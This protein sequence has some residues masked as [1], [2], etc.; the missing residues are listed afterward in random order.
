[1][2]KWSSLAKTA[3]P[4]RIVEAASIASSAGVETAAA[5][6]PIYAVFVLLI[7]A[8]IVSMVVL[9]ANRNSKE[10]TDT[11]ASSKK[12]VFEEVPIVIQPKVLQQEEDPVATKLASLAQHHADVQDAIVKPK[13]S[14]VD[15]FFS[16]PEES[17]DDAVLADGLSYNEYLSAFS[18]GREMPVS[19][20]GIKTGRFEA[21][22]GLQGRELE[23]YLEANDLAVP[24]A[25]VD[26]W[27]AGPMAGPTV[28][29]ASH[30]D[31][32]EDYMLL[33]RESMQAVPMRSAGDAA[34]VLREILAARTE[35]AKLGLSMPQMPEDQL[36]NVRYWASTNGHAA[37]L[38][39]SVLSRL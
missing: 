22:G 38:A 9:G 29:A 28:G 25:L 17:L 7:I 4:A 33:A 27:N 31:Y 39:K 5:A 8:G 32:S 23:A 35:A 1:M 3:T 10:K 18:Q 30:G 14:A 19:D 13:F 20:R 34:I 11:A 12:V 21:P 16:A 2:S 15:R 37:D 26:A 24:E 36:S 6:S